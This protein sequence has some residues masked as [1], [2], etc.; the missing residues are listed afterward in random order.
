[1]AE[2]TPDRKFSVTFMVGDTIKTKIESQNV[3]PLEAI[4]LLE[5]AKDQL[6]NNL[7]S[8]T[9]NILNIEKKDE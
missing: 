7:R 9:Q 1:M 5:M 2:P 3:K 8:N 4:A 6:M